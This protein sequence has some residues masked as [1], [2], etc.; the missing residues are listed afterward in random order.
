[1][2]IFKSN[3]AYRPFAY[4]WAVDAE[5]KHRIDMLWH[6]NQIDLQ[7]DLRQFTSKDGLKIGNTSHETNKHIIGSLNML[8]TE[9]DVAVGSGYCELLPYVKN[10]EIRTMWL[11]F[12]S[13]EVLHQRAYALAA[14]TFGYTDSEWADFRRYKEMSDK[15]DLMTQDVGELSDVLNFCKK[16]SVIL[17]GEG[18]SL[19]G[20]FSVLLN[21]QRSGKMIGFN[22]INEWSLKDE[23]EHVKN[24][25][26]V[27]EVAEKDL[28]EAEKIELNRWFEKV[29][30]AYIDAEHLFLDTVFDI[31]DQED[32]SKEEAKEFISYLG[33]L[34]LYQKGIKTVGEVR[35]N[36]LPWMDYILSASTHTN[37]FEA[38]VVDYSHN[39][40]SGHIDY[41]VYEEALSNA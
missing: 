40:L 9:M 19:F 10:N 7:D 14:E 22:T 23:Q 1:M 5:K 8:F 3:I 4:N 12:G 6:E 37:F 35:D 34:R 32:M 36:P 33:D 21:Y 2:S 31:G 18:I 17:L 11:T 38:K 28:T 39:G 15:I 16:L 20:A 26:K 24:N 13:R 27:L 41:S 25:L 30:T 29:V